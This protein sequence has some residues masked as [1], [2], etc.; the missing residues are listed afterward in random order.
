MQRLSV[1]WVPADR[2]TTAI[3]CLY[4]FRVAAERQTR[5]NARLTAEPQQMQR[6]NVSRVPVDRQ[7]IAIDAFVRLAVPG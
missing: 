2:Q 3:D 7:T 6:L 5:A 1:S 4:V